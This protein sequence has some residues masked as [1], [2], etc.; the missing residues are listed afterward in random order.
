MSHNKIQKTEIFKLKNNGRHQTSDYLAVETP[1]EI[2]LAHDNENFKTLAITMCSPQDIDDLI[3]G[4]LFTESIINSVSDIISIEVFDNEFGLIAEVILDSSVAFETF[5]NKRH[6]MVHASCGL[7]GKTEFDD[8]LTYNY[9]QIISENEIINA[10]VIQSLPK[11][12]NQQQQA[13]TKTGGLHASALFNYKGELILIKEDIGR[14]NALDKLIGAALQQKLLPLSDYIILL[15][16]RI[17]FELVHK[18][19]MAGVS[20][21]AAIGAPSSLS[22]EIAKLN[23]LNLIGFIKSDG[24]NLYNNITLNK[25]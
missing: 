6:G 22:V 10:N 23:G 4:Y 7:C 21:L 15:S 3:Y 25:I 17:S 5:L 18:A 24:Y 1:L 11:K 19:L 12:L 9:T 20:T 13:F 14:H 16:G 2:R 8:L